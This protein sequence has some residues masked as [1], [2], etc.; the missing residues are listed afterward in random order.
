MSC[1]KLQESLNQLRD[2]LDPETQL[3]DLSLVQQISHKLGDL[4]TKAPHSHTAALMQAG[5]SDWADSVINEWR[6]QGQELVDKYKNK[7]PVSWFT[8]FGYKEQGILYVTTSPEFDAMFP[9]FIEQKGINPYGAWLSCEGYESDSEKPE[10]VQ[11]LINEA[12]AVILAKT[13]CTVLQIQDL[14]LQL[15]NDYTNKTQAPFGFEL[16]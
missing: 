13:G 10:D 2:R 7:P 11:R 16:Y 9:E 6:Q 5:H 1:E 8:G 3:D 14:H 4:C 12:E 15:M